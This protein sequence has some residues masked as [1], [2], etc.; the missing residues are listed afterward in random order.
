MSAAIS[1]KV[2]GDYFEGCNCQ[3]ICPCIIL[4]DPDEGDC[5]LTI[6]WHIQ[7]GHYGST[8]LDGLNV[9]GIFHTPG[10]MVTGPK[11][12]AALYLDDHANKE[13]AEALGKIFSG[14]GGGFLA[15]VADLIGE[16]M[17]VRTAP[18]QFGIDGKRRWLRIPNILDIEVEGITGGDPN[19]DATVTNPPLYAGAGFDPV[20]SRSTK[21][22]YHDHGLEWDNTGKNG[23]YSNFAYAP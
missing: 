2:E 1:W 12:R 22:T 5:K 10:N 15:N 6:G 18:I 8:R 16:V 20:I 9:A 19:S 17:G 3:S 13:Q 14:Q 23:F 11:W 21:D 4:A 7:K